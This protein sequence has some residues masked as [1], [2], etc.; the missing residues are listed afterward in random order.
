M[1]ENNQLKVFNFNLINS[2]QENIFLKSKIS[3]LQAMINKYKSYLP[4]YG[5]NVKDR[6]SCKQISNDV[7]PHMLMMEVDGDGNPV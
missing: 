7:Y 2:N 1:Q 6:T 4:Q 5:Y 3:K